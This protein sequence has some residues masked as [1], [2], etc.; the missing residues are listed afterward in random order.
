VATEITS[1]FIALHQRLRKIVLM[2]DKD[3]H[4]PEVFEQRMKSY[5][6]DEW[7]AFANAHLSPSPVSVRIHPR[8]Q[9]STSALPSVPWTKFGRYLDKRPLFTLDPLLHAGAYYV[10]E[11]SSMF[12]EQAFTRSVNVNDDLRVLDLSAAPGGK[13]TH[14]L[15]LLDGKGLLVTNEVIQ[16]RAAILSENIQKWGYSNVLVTNNDPSDFSNLRSF[17]DVIVVDAP[18]SGEGLF[19]K[20]PNAMK[21]WSP[22]NVKLCAARQ[23]RILHDIWPSL[24]EDGILIYSTCTFNE[25]ENEQNLTDFTAQHDAEFVELNVPSEWN[26]VTV[27][28]DKAIGY[29]FMPHKVTGEG[30]FIS[31]LRKKESDHATSFKSKHKLTKA[32]KTIVEKLSRWVHHPEIFSFIQHKDLVFVI[33]QAIEK[34]IEHLLQHL[35]FVYA[36]TNLATMKHEKAIPEH[37]LALS[38][39]LNTSAFAMID[40]DK[41]TALEYLR[42]NTVQL[43]PH[44]KGYAL[45]IYENVPIGWVNILDNRVNNLYPQEWRIRMANP[46]SS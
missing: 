36:G 3:F 46:V 27:K 24:K 10:Q 38:V 13:S 29:R 5:L 30:F 9:S 35:K 4:F 15:S 21:E 7:E 44:P 16:S 23:S 12:L 6:H 34:D 14:L 18:C 8:K 17:F 42:R 40:V 25:T 19:R 37:A 31:V 32:S 43:G 22:D 20:D 11:A 28:A 45:L 2:N 41:N 1:D 33:P 39:S 26:V